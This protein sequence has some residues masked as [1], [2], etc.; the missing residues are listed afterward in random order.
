MSMVSRM[1]LIGAADVFI[2]PTNEAVFCR[3]L[4]LLALFHHSNHCIDPNT[5]DEAFT[6]RQAMGDGS[7]DADRRSPLAHQDGMSDTGVDTGSETVE[8]QPSPPSQPANG[9]CRS[10]QTRSTRSIA[11]CYSLPRSA[12]RPSPLYC[13][14]LSGM[15]GS[16]AIPRDGYRMRRWVRCQVKR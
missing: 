11:G 12:R 6:N 4:R 9:G 13:C 10:S 14:R 16:R 7:G 8:G 15:I 3:S 1:L 5:A 2:L